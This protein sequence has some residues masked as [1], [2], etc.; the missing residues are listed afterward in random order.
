ME[1]RRE[2]DVKIQRKGVLEVG[3]I[4][5]VPG[6]RKFQR[7]IDWKSP[8]PRTLGLEVGG[9]GTELQERVPAG[10]GQRQPVRPLGLPPRV[11]QRHIR[12]RVMLAGEEEPPTSISAGLLQVPGWVP[13]GLRGVSLL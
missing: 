1:K 9:S 8:W 2:L 5:K 7:N 3:A 4:P 12:H 13:L 11:S 10:P 6:H